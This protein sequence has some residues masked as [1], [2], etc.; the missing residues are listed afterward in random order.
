MACFQNQREHKRQPKVISKRSTS[1][2]PEHASEA[3][4]PNQ[5]RR[6]NLKA[7][8]VSEFSCAWF[9]H[10]ENYTQDFR[11]KK[12]IKNNLLLNFVAQDGFL[13]KIAS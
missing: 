5:R 9:S 3:N 7:T 4:N 8:L 10:F 13:Y 11:S 2:I 1:E 12:E 6:N